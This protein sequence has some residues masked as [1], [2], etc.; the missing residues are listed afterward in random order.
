MNLNK[1]EGDVTPILPAKG[2]LGSVGNLYNLARNRSIEART[3]LAQEICSILEADITVR[4]SEMIADVLIELL[5][6]VEKNVRKALA[7]KLSL[8]EHAPLRLIL[9]LANDDID[10]AWPI[11][12]TSRALGDFD[13][14]YIVKSQSSEYWK[15]I[16]TRKA[17]GDKV[18][19]MLAGTRDI[20][21]ALT[22][23]ENKDVVLSDNTMVL[24]SDIAQ[25][26][27]IVAIPLLCRNEMT[28]DLAMTLYQ[29]VGDEVKRYISEHYDMVENDVVECLA[30]VVKETAQEQETA[31]PS[32]NNLKDVMLESAQAA[33]RKG[34]LNVKMMIGSL[35]R[36]QMRSFVAQLSTYTGIQT[37]VITKI[38]MQSNG[39]GLA[40]VARAYDI[41]KQDFIS[42]FMLTG[43]FWKDGQ[44]IHPNDVRKALQYYERASREFALEFIQ[45]QIKH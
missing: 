24:L 22:L 16:A 44:Y 30:R 42:L 45:P 41:S 12:S 23:L 26:E 21:T 27:E 7:L 28:N 9:E 10:V 29:F 3:Q 14:M 17:L 4:E 37:D 35:R 5:A 40:L 11:L 20:E 31:A 32:E 6:E 18:V 8:L 2:Y 36:G 33:K 34:I 38:L 15:A 19:E 43:K 13:L 1:I 25:Q 39:Q